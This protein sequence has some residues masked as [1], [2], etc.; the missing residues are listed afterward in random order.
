MTSRILF[1]ILVC[2]SEMA[3]APALDKKG[4]ANCALSCTSVATTVNGIA[5]GSLII[6]HIF[7][8]ENGACSGTTTDRIT[9]ISN[10]TSNLTRRVSLIADPAWASGAIAIY[11]ETISS[12]GNI[13]F[14]ASFSS[15]VYYARLSV[16]SW[17]GTTAA[18]ADQTG[19]HANAAGAAANVTTSGNLTASNQLLFA[20][21]AVQ[22]GTVGL[23]TGWTVVN[24]TGASGNADEYLIGGT[25]GSTVTATFTSS[26]AASVSVIAT[27]K[28][29]ESS[30]RQVRV[31][32]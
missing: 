2:L 13:T 23:S 21:T 32:Q 31:I 18:L 9:S 5:S 28:S 8:C 20:A 6:A 19:S 26:T 22:S 25:I 24:L 7:W 17:T 30:R 16:S 4:T 10:G 29:N 15:S 14:T 1:A 3:A 27:Y 11:D 12:G